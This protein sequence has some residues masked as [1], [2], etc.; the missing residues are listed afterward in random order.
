[1]KILNKAI[2]V[3]LLIALY[4]PIAYGL[5]RINLDDDVDCMAL[6]IYHEAK[7]QS[8]IGQ[9]AVALVVMNRVNDNR[10]PNRICEV[11]KEG[12]TRPSWKD[13]TKEHPIKHRCQF[14][15]WCD[16]K[17]DEPLY[18]SRAWRVAQDYAYLVL[19]RRIMDVTEGATH[20][21]ASYVRPAWAKT[22][23]RTT[24]IETHIFYRWEK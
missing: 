14:S 3:G 18:D 12:P 8:M 9:V 5:E 11:I 17:S 15:W 24:R 13:P 10:Y 16:G 21:H 19:T 4:S 1:M 22:K 6:N 2:A 20:Y 23:T 7:N